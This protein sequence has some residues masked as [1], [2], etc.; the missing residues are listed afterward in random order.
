MMRP[1]GGCCDFICRNAACRQKNIP[2]RLTSTTSRHWSAVSSSSGT[3][4]A[5]TPALLKQQIDSTERLHGMLK[6]MTD[7]LGIGDV[8]SERR[9]HESRPPAPTRSSR[10]ADRPAG[11]PAQPTIPPPKARGGMASDPRSGPGHDRDAFRHQSSA[12]R[13]PNIE[14][15]GVSA[16]AN[17]SRGGQNADRREISCTAVAPGWSAPATLSVSADFDRHIDL[18]RRWRSPPRPETHRPV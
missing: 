2:V 15:L 12:I 9:S 14:C 8:G 10:P 6:Q 1:P 11:R 17:A 5:L 18:R 7:G 16:L 13:S 3:A 4:G